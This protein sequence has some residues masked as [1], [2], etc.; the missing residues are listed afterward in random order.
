MHTVTIPDLIAGTAIKPTLQE[1]TNPSLNTNSSTN[2]ISLATLGGLGKPA[3][4]DSFVELNLFTMKM[5]NLYMS[6]C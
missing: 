5:L 6:K 2:S 1:N 4:F 3:L